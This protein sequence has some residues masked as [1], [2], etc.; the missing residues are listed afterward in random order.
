MS[1]AD[2]VVAALAEMVRTRRWQVGDKVPPEAEL[3]EELGVSRGSLREA[4]R[5]LS[6]AG[7]LHVRQ[8]DGTYVSSLEPDLVLAPFRLAVGLTGPTTL[9]ELYGVRRIL[10]PAATALAVT[11]LTDDD[12]ATLDR[13]L[14]AMTTAAEDDDAEVFVAADAE[15]HDV[16]ARA[17]GNEAL[18]ALL[19]ALRTEAA[20]TL[21]GRARADEGATAQTIDEH[22]AVLDALRTGDPELARAAATM[23]LAAGERW[24]RRALDG[25]G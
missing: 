21:I 1:R 10:E 23:H 3:A 22:R 20:R 24:L 11:R 15:F 17:S 2:E 18:R 4:V 9:V 25:A 19:D 5:Q 13:L 12:L 7:V 14:D 6:F 8:G 16:V